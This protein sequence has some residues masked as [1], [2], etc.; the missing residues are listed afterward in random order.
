MSVPLWASELAAE[1]WRM[2]SEPEPFPRGLR[3]PIIRSALDLTVK[4][5]KGLTVRR[6][7]R[8][9][10]GLGIGWAA[11]GLDRA[12]R[13]CLAA[14]GGAGFIFI[15]AADP[16]DEQRFSLAHELAHFLRHYL[17]PRR[18]AVGRIGPDV[19]EVLD[20]GRPPTAAET[21]HGLLRGVPIEPYVHL[22][23]RSEHG[24]MSAAAAAAESEA[25]R[26]AFELLAPADVV[27]HE[28]A[29]AETLSGRLETVF[30]LPPSAARVYARVLLS[31]RESPGGL[32]ARLK[33][34][35]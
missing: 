12:L 9:L 21:L 4:D 23:D 33:I 24:E 27:L 13:A 32:L 28:P 26:L 5:L 14:R 8:Y 6:I 29:G 7:E 10:A 19:L 34:S 35:P 11:V 30:G 15:D 2:T 1:F 20:R 22:L 16:P 3:G 17:E 18:R 31:T 25:D